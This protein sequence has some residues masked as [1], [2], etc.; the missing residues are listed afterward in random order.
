MGVT[1]EDK[2]SSWTNPEDGEYL[3]VVADVI[4]LGLVV[5]KFGAKPKVQIVFLLDAFDPETGD[6]F[7]VSGFY[8]KSKHEKAGLR[9]AVKAILGFDALATEGAIDLDELLLG[10]NVKLVT[11]QVEGKESKIYCN[12]VAILKAPKG[13]VIEIPAEFVRKIDR[14]GTGSTATPVNATKKAAPVAAKKAAPAA[15]PAVSAPAATAVADEDIP[16]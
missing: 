11:E 4:D 16:F 13:K 2:P 15:K 6:Q 14:E 9:K 8:T 1:V 12:I 3:A 10:K 7:R 5:G